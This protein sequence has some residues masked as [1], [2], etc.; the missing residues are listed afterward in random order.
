MQLEMSPVSRISNKVLFRKK[1]NIDY[2]DKGLDSQRKRFKEISLRRPSEITYDVLKPL[3]V[4]FRI[5]SL[6]Q[7]FFAIF[8][9]FFKS[10]NKY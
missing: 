1:K 6:E 9:Y 7:T 2:T 5:S 8:I 10:Y 4:V 3:A